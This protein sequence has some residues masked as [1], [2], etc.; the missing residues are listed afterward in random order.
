MTRFVKLLSL[1]F[2]F[3]V[4]T[5]CSKSLGYS[6]VLWSDAEHNLV[7]GQIVKVYIRSNILHE[8]V[9]TTLDSDEK[10]E[11]PLWQLTEPESKSKAL[12]NAKKFAAYEHTYAVVKLDGLPVRAEA[13]NTSKQV[14]RLRQNEIL[15]ILYKGHGQSV[16][17]GDGQMK[18]EWLRVLTE[19]GT[20]GWCFS[21][22]LE[23][24]TAGI[25]VKSSVVKT[26]SNE[27][28]EKVDELLNK[29]LEK[30]WYPEEFD[31][32]IKKK[33]V[34]ISRMDSEYGFDFGNV[35]GKIRLFTADEDYSWD[36]EGISKLYGKQ[37]QLDGTKI[38]ITIKDENN[39]VVQFFDK[40]RKIKSENFVALK[41]DIN[42]EEIIE[43]EKIRRANVIKHI[44]EFGPKFVS[45]SYG[46][47]FFSEDGYVT[48]TD[49]SLLVQQG[50]V[51]ASVAGNASV[52]VEYF[53]HDSLKSS[54][55][56]ALTFNFGGVKKVNFFYKLTADGL[57]LE[58][59]VRAEIR[60]GE[61]ILRAEGNSLLVMFFEKI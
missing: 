9:V 13:V 43:N 49:N 12:N 38:N 10:F 30:K 2:L 61:K 52:S 42:I 32:M 21:H 57:R 8:Y 19:Q 56:G 31:T 17:N 3:S 29:V 46:T 22:N 23:L 53:I 26:S 16:T 37:Y 40:N 33:R 11:I 60:E 7:D 48:W 28:T 15:R 18:G 36:F 35:S 34:D 27:E 45:S 50:I 4:L 41:D 5:S 14:Y 44:A 1:L 55:D 39:I 54:Y 25:D 47:L 20:Q 6:V 51:D 59:A 24:F 58:D